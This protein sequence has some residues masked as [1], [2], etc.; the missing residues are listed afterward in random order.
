MNWQ[1]FSCSLTKKSSDIG[2][3][4]IAYTI[5]IKSGDQQ[6]KLHQFNSPHY[7]KLLP[8]CLRVCNSIGK[9]CAIVN[10]IPQ[11]SEC[12][13]DTIYLFCETSLLIH[14][15]ALIHKLWHNMFVIAFPCARYAISPSPFAISIVYFLPFFSLLLLALTYTLAITLYYSISIC[16]RA[17]VRTVCGVA[18]V[19]LKQR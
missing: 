11:V 8:V 2:F 12:V 9:I 16:I 14:C 6:I 15:T 5:D 7:G 4:F 18:F 13:C 3:S 17:C 10:S 1:S 19:E